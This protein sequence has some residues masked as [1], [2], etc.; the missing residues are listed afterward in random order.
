MNARSF[1]LSS[2]LLQ[3]GLENSTELKSCYLTSASYVF[4]TVMRQLVK[5]WKRSGHLTL[6]YLDGDG[7]GGDRAFKLNIKVR[8]V[9]ILSHQVS[10]RM[11][12]SHVGCQY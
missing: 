9:R 2:G 10:L 12:K 11:M 8:R 3:K 4:T 7:L 5:Y 1:C 6:V